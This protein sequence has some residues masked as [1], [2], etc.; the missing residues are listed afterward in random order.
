MDKD[1]L[2][3]PAAPIRGLCRMTPE[4]A[5]RGYRLSRFLCS[6]RDAGQRDAAARDLEACLQAH[7][8]NET[9]K[10]MVRRRDFVAMLDHGASTVA[11]GKACRAW[12][13][14]LVELGAIGR[15][16]SP[17]DFITERRRANRG[18][19]WDF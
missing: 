15:G 3:G 14:S 9:E 4:R 5:Q 8:L 12:G 16:Q 17:Q 10:D 19:P 11:V 6:L 7:G 18:Q 13:V 2:L 1:H